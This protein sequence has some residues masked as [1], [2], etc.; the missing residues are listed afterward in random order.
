FCYYRTNNKADAEDLTAQIFLAVLEALPRYRQ[1]GHFAG[2]LFSIA[3]NKINDHH[4]RVSHIPL[5]ESTLPP[6]HA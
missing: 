1:Q 2:W 6:L 4:R 5:D 3:R